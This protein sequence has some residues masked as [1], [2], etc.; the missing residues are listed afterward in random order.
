VVT[1]FSVI[2]RGRVTLNEGLTDEGF[3]SERP[4]ASAVS[5]NVTPQIV[6][7]PDQPHPVLGVNGSP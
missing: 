7:S 4:Y 5:K 6:G 1:L 2:R 3:V